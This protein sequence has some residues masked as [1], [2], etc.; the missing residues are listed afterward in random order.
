MPLAQSNRYSLNRDTML[1]DA[2]GQP[3][4]E[5]NVGADIDITVDVDTTRI[6]GGVGDSGRRN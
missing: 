6:A 1:T 2:S 5:S 3:V 4:S